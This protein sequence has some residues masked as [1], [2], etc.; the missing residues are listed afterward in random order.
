[1]PLF[2][3]VKL[4]C[5]TMQQMYANYCYPMPAENVVPK[6]LKC[7]TCMKTVTKKYT[8]FV[9]KKLKLSEIVVYRSSFRYM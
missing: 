3:F 7:Q 8:G 6:I 4:I 9:V 5:I 2:I 1:M